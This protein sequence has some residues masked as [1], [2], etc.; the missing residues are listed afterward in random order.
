MAR[1]VYAD[2]AATTSV[3]NEV[4]SVITDTLKNTYGNPSSLYEMGSKAKAVVDKA[5]SDREK[6]KS[7]IV[8]YNN[9]YFIVTKYHNRKLLELF[10]PFRLQ[11][12]G[13][14]LLILHFFFCREMLLR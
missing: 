9:F 2:N 4:I 6:V 7:S 11:S 3:S 5:R 13:S 1:F 8:G 10:V 14:R 12:L